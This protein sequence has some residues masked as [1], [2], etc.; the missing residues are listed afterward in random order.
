M[1]SL[2]PR[3][4]TYIHMWEW[5]RKRTRTWEK[6]ATKGKERVYVCVCVRAGERVRWRER[7]RHAH[8]QRSTQVRSSE[9]QTQKRL[10]SVETKMPRRW[11]RRDTQMKESRKNE[12]IP[13]YTYAY[14]L[15]N[16][17]IPTYIGAQTWHTDEGVAQEGVPP[18]LYKRINMYIQQN[19][20][21]YAHVHMFTMLREYILYIYV[22]TSTC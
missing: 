18:Y 20:Y 2:S 4:N 3:V 14:R 22:Y 21:E 7:D 19:G 15:T 12:Y 17:I 8:T 5:E 10:K 13:T 11:I 16:I 6:K 9:T 1:Y